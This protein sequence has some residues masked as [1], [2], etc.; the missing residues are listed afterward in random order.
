MLRT[1]GSDLPAAD[2]ASLFAGGPSGRERGRG[3][4]GRV[5]VSRRL[6]WAFEPAQHERRLSVI[7]EGCWNG[8]T[9][10][11]EVGHNRGAVQPAAH[12]STGSVAHSNDGNDVMCYAPDGGDRNQ[13]MTYPC[14][15][16]TLFDYGYDDYF[17]AAP[18]AAWTAAP[19]ARG[20]RPTPTA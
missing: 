17:D 9:F 1:H 5:A 15:G 2:P 14:R 6:A 7:Y 10:M 3:M 13:S 4:W 20:R 11:H 18:D 8:T 12:H 19:S 16:V